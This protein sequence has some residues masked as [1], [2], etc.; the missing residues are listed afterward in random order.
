MNKHT[1]KRGEDGLVSIVVVSVIIVILSLMTIG[2][3]RVMD[4]ELRQSLDRELASQANY[5]AESAMNDAQNYIRQLLDSGIDPSTAGKCLDTNSTPPG[6]TLGTSPFVQ[7]GSISGNYSNNPA[8]NIVRYS[9]VI[10][11]TKAREV[12]Y[13]IPAGQSRIFK[14][15]TP[16]INKMYFSWENKDY[17]APGGIPQVSPFIT[18]PPQLPQESDTTAS[19]TGMLRASIYPVPSNASASLPS[20]NQNAIVNNN[21]RTFFFYPN[22]SSTAG[23]VGATSW[24]NNG[25][26]VVGNCNI[27]NRT[28]PTTYLP[29]KSA[30]G[31]YCNSSVSSIPGGQAFYYLRLTSLYQNVSVSVQGSD[32][33][34]GSMELAGAQATIDI[35]AKG[36]DVLKRLEGRMPLS[37]D[38][39][40]PF[41]AVDSMST[42]CKK[43][44]L[45]KTGPGA[46]EFGSAIIDDSQAADPGADCQPQGVAAVPP[47]PGIPPPPPGATCSAG[48]KSD[49]VFALDASGSMAQSFNGGASK[50]DVLKSALLDM[51]S[52]LNIS[53]NGNHVGVTAFD[54]IPWRLAEL[55]GNLDTVNAAINFISPGGRTYMTPVLDAS[56]A[57]M[58][59]PGTSRPGSSVNRIVVLVTDGLPTDS[60]VSILAAAQNLKNQ[61][62]I[63]DTI[64]VATDSDP[65]ARALLASVA[66]PTGT[67]TSVSSPAELQALLI[68]LRGD[69]CSR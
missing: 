21:A 17:P 18:T 41:A 28:N 14:I 52:N 13:D 22:G 51:V 69:I 39:D 27:A 3:A 54:D 67:F 49:I 6:V 31:R 23:S 42:I 33:A 2:F 55:S 35:T 1:A 58:T 11:N 66:S 40:Y 50:I 36:N 34:T 63:I 43:F 19:T 20:D 24:S 59:N 29:F 65:T 46:N 56:N 64:G 15:T 8:D 4:R 57:V 9:C 10:I 16:N 30:T 53:T 61:G 38:F 12:K 26:I 32:P 68:R 5:A 60:P 37:F 25:G 47:P 48:K 44:R 7:K 62:I 45:P